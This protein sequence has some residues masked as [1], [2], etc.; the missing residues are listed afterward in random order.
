ML[1]AKELGIEN[2]VCIEG[3][4]ENLGDYYK[5]ASVLFHAAKYEGYGVVL[6]EAELCGLA[7]VSSNVGIADQIKRSSV[8]SVGDR[9]MAASLLGKA[10][11]K[12]TRS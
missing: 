8:Y 11:E 3:W 2:L 9:N 12:N 1:K 7:V 6:K 5:G 10:I 4:Q